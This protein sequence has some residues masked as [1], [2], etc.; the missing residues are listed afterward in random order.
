M[1]KKGWI[2]I[3]EA[4]ISILLIISVGLIVINRG[5]V[6]GDISNEVYEK[7]ILILREVQLNNT[8]RESILNSEPPIEWDD[9]D[10][11]AN[12]KDKIN[13]KTPGYL[14]CNAKICKINSD[15]ILEEHSRE[16]IYAESVIITSSLE[17]YSPKQL[18][19]FCWMK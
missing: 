16:N 2:K 9:A 14:E 13:E 3:L 19:I 4:F 15:C 6:S 5:G 17:T 12:V 18:K 7:E 1:N 11:P 10:F 8:L